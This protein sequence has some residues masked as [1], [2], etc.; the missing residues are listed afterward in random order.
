MVHVMKTKRKPSCSEKKI[1]HQPF[2][3]GLL[4]GYLAVSATGPQVP[5]FFT[6]TETII[7]TGTIT[8]RTSDGGAVSNSALL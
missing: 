5:T 7:T 3:D 1:G 6:V 8:G 4:Q 2:V